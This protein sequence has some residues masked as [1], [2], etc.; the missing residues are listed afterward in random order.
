MVLY[1]LNLPVGIRRF[2]SLLVSDLAF[3]GTFTGRSGVH[4]PDQ[5]WRPCL[6]MI[7]DSFGADGKNSGN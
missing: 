7:R 2:K 1:Y 5:V 4:I 6:K 3:S